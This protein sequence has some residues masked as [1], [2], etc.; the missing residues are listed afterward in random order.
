[1][2]PKLL[3][4]GPLTLHTY[5]AL[6]AAAC[7][8]A[9]FLFARLGAR[10]GVPRQRSWDLGFI[11]ILSAIVGAKLL[12]ILTDWETYLGRDPSRLLTLGFWQAGGVYYGGLL[13]A[14]AGSYIYVR[15][16]P[17]MNFRTVAD[18]AGPAIA[19][20]QTIGRLGCFAAG[21]D[22]G[23]PCSLPWAVTFTS[24]Y[25]H[26]VVGVPINV[27]L[28]PTQLYESLA[29]FTLFLFLLW[30]HG[31]RRFRGQVF[32]AYLLCYSILRFGI[33]FFRGDADRGFVFGGALSTSQF[34]SLL[35]IPCALLL[36]SHMRR[37]P[38]RARR[39]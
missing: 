32:A 30:L 38:V 10:D 17:S 13:G 20:G 23:Q 8:S 28:H 11:I 9:I 12:M 4:I 33:E 3:E 22:Y 36:Y 25:A 15:R 35:L 37:N 39:V 24:E 18:A 31:A 19:L 21:C 16:Q 27:A 2:F 1:M 29:T 14:M 5:G 26:R 6:L 34:I 7:L